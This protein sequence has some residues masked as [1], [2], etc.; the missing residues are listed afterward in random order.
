VG[1]EL[2]NATQRNKYKNENKNKKYG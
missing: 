1:R 2:N